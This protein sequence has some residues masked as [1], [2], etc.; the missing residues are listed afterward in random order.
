MELQTRF[1]ITFAKCQE[2]NKKYKKNEPTLIAN[3]GIIYDKSV[4]PIL[5]D[6]EIEHFMDLQIKYPEIINNC[7]NNL[8]VLLEEREKQII[9]RKNK[10]SR[11]LQNTPMKQIYD[12]LI[13]L[14]EYNDMEMIDK[15][16][17]FI[18]SQNEF[19]KFF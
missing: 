13:N 16:I 18:K 9:T 4:I 5:T 3:N 14:N 6:N 15:W 11:T 19:S 12:S 1:P 8:I 10:K 17:L 7:F 2:H